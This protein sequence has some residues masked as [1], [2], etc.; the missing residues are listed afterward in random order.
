MH[1]RYARRLADAA[2]S[3]RR[4]VIRLTV[5]RFFCACAACKS[6]TFAEQ[7]PGLTA[8]YARK[9]P[10]L[11]GAQRD[12]AVA[13]AGRAASRLARTLGVPASR[14]VLLRLIMATPDPAVGTPR[15]LGVGGDR[16][17]GPRRNDRA[18]GRPA[19]GGCFRHDHDQ[20]RRRGS[21][22]RRGPGRHGSQQAIVAG[23][24]PLLADSNGY[25]WNG[26][27]IVASGN[28]LADF[29]A[30][31]AAEAQGRVQTAR[32]YNMTDDPGV[33]NMLKFNLARDT[34]HQNLWLKAIEELQADGL[35]TT[36]APN[37]Q[38]D[39]E[40]ASTQPRCG[41]CRT[42][43]RGTRAAG[44]RDRSPTACMSSVTCSIPSRWAAP[45]RRQPRTR[46]CT[47]P[48]TVSRASLPARPSAPKPARPERSRTSSPDRR[49]EASRDGYGDRTA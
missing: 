42:A 37:A 35:E 34:L 44:R 11:A 14:Q 1:S 43:P 23:G 39:E 18:H 45:V 30:N 25:P 20:G 41:T 7:V 40:Y 47:R 10:P 17:N 22:R 28:L 36:V 33:R 26:R 4:V 29:L 49:A 38:F 46:S 3:G 5:H 16:G 12:I 19:A 13:L 9:T 31:A 27:Y 2:I 15:V 21:G 32:L 48:T 6:R 8:R 24:G